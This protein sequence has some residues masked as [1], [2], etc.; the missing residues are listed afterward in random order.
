MLSII[1]FFY[2]MFFFFFECLL[3]LSLRSMH[4]ACS[5]W[6]CTWD[7][8]NYQITWSHFMKNFL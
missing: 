3:H 7:C 1:L 6:F 2:M 8:G 5:L 4:V